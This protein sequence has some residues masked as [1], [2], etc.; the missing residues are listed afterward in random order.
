MQSTNTAPA[1]PE[2]CTEVEAYRPSSAPTDGRILI[3]CPECR[4]TGR[5]DA[6]LVGK[7]V[8][9]KKCSRRIQLQAPQ[10]ALAVLVGPPEDQAGQTKTHAKTEL[11]VLARHLPKPK[12][13]ARYFNG[14]SAKAGSFK[15]CR[16][17]F[18]GLRLQVDFPEVVEVGTGKPCAWYT[19]F[20]VGLAR[21]ELWIVDLHYRVGFGDVFWPLYKP[22]LVGWIISGIGYSAWQSFHS[23]SEFVP[24]AL[25]VSAVAAFFAFLGACL[26]YCTSSKSLCL[27]KLEDG[28][29]GAFVFGVVEA[30]QDDLFGRLGRAGWLL[31]RAGETENKRNQTSGEI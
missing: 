7:W 12:I 11:I 10:V 25:A 14:I 20:E 3:Q 8:R 27:V 22:R 16:L 18:D 21:R 24:L 5:V 6:G 26:K 19:V 15:D 23:H 29:R 28:W 13:P 2:E 4:A 9:C 17:I 1:A 31:H 30:N